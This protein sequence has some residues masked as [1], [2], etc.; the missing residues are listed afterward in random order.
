MSAN[1]DPEE[2]VVLFADI[3]ESTH[4]YEELGDEAASRSKTLL[5]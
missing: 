3:G 1:E 5:I 4:L 2:L